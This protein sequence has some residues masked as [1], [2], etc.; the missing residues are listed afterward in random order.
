MAGKGFDDPSS[1]MEVVLKKLVLHIARL[2]MAISASREFQSVGR[3]F[4]AR[5]H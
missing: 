5:R 1:L 4:A 3:H 2:A